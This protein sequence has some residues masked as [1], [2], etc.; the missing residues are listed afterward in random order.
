[1]RNGHDS[2]AGA[3][4]PRNTGGSAFILGANAFS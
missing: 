2:H 1:V 3:H 4:C